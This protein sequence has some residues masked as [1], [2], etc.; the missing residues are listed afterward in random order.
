[1]S[2]MQIHPAGIVLYQVAFVGRS[3]GGPTDAGAQAC[4]QVLGVG[5]LFAYTGSQG[6]TETWYVPPSLAID[7]ID[8]L[9]FERTGSVVESGAMPRY[10]APSR[11]FPGD[12]QSETPPPEQ[13]G[14]TFGGIVRGVDRAKVQLSLGLRVLDGS[15]RRVVWGL[16]SAC[17]GLDLDGA[18]LE[19]KPPS[20]IRHFYTGGAP[21]T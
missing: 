18:T 21:M 2:F 13:M 3:S 11:L 16:G 10:M 14:R 20:G 19:H 4:E 9:R 17:S 8:V 6:G 5:G 12:W 7:Q 1:M 15:L